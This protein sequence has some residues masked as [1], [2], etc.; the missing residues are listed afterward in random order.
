MSACGFHATNGQWGWGLPKRMKPKLYLH[1]GAHRTATSSIQAFLQRNL[2]ALAQRGI[3]VPWQTGRPRSQMTALFRGGLS[4][5]DMSAQILSQIEALPARGN[6]AAAVISD[7][8]IAIHTDLTPLAALADSFD[9]RPVFF[10]RRQDLWL[11]SWF[12]QNVKWQWNPRLA[13]MT[14]P[15]FLSRRE[16]FHWIRYDRMV[17]RLEA[18]FGRENLILR[19]FEAEQMPGGPLTAFAAAVGIGP[20]EGLEI[21]GRVNASMSPMMT[22][23]MRLLPLRSLTEAQRAIV[24][25]ACDEAD[26][27]LRA[28]SK[29]PA[30][31][32]DSATRAAVMRDYAPGNAEL[33]HSHM[34][35]PLLF[36]E[37]MPAEDAPLASQALPASSYETVRKLV[38]P[39]LMELARRPQG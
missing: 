33:A 14:F 18:L 6:T 26:R 20:L 12:Q 31:Y 27:A 15:E 36:L 16:E 5:H 4:A 30:L 13:H 23:F 7:E 29:G 3:L 22:E 11:E 25:R 21:P 32:M 24:E 1:I 39:V 37:P 35:R 9:L 17:Q 19:V 10:L 2:D 34:G 8:D 28:E 38:V